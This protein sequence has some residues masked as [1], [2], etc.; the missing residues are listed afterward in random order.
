MRVSGTDLE[1]EF[2]RMVNLDGFIQPRHAYLTNL[3]DDAGALIDQCVVIYFPAPA[4][5]TG[6]DVI[7]IHSHGA[8]AVINKIFEHLHRHGMRMAEPGEFSRRA[9]YNNKMD[10]VEV[11]ALAALLDARTDKQRA[12]ALKSMSGDDST[13]YE[14]W[15]ALMVEI[16]AYAAAILDYASDDLPVNIGEKLVARTQKLHAEINDALGTYAS[17]RAIRNGFNIVLVGETNVGKSSIFNRLVG[18]SRAIVSDIPGTTRDVISTELDID[19]YLVNLLDTAG[20]RDSSDTIENIGIAKTH[21]MIASADL[22][23]RVRCA[24]CNAPTDDLCENEI[25]VINKS[26]LLNTSSIA[27]RPSYIHLS[28]K[29]GDGIDSLLNAIKQKIHEQLDGAE[30]QLAVN[31]RTRGLLIDAGR[32][33]NDAIKNADG[34]YDIFSEHVRAAADSIGKILGVIDATEIMDATFGQLCLGK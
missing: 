6:E 30:S 25:I 12:V 2:S 23:I 24:D 31:A 13:V 32:E 27:N 4:S 22:V 7:E 8:P 3:I 16:A 10:L 17:A 18:T 9:F 21:E 11:D 26:D 20:I 15:R 5:F 34:N 29:T 28:A 19:G 14:Q 33:L 1:S